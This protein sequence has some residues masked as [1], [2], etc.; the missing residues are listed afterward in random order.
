MM[1]P[2]RSR[3]GSYLLSLTCAGSLSALAACDDRA[4]NQSASYDRSPIGSGTGHP[5]VASPHAEPVVPRPAPITDSLHFDLYCELRGRVVSDPHP[6]EYIGTSTDTSLAWRDRG[7]FVV[8]LE[9]MQVCDSSV[10]EQYGPFHIRANR[11]RITLQDVPGATI[12]ISRH[13]WRYEQR[14]E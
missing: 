5:P 7:H 14:Q 9:A 3:I 12:F 10:C 1:F 6:E 4:P 13:D 2:I 11:D 8:D